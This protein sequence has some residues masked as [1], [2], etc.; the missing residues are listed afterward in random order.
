[1]NGLGQTLLDDVF[2][3]HVVRKANSILGWPG[4]PLRGEFHISPY[5]STH[6]HTTVNVNVTFQHICVYGL[7]CGFCC[8]KNFPLG[9]IHFAY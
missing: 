3:S 9:I 4:H 5:L 7:H 2:N 8:R 6:I 1:M